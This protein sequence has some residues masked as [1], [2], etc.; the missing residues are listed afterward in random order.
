[1]LAQG[2]ILMQP[3]LKLRQSDSKILALRSMLNVL[4]VPIIPSEWFH[5]IGS[6]IMIAVDVFHTVLLRSNNKPHF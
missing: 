3:E 2:D 1:M 6:F 5:Y 4:L